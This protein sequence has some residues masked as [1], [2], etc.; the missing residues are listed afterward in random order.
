MRVLSLSLDGTILDKHSL[1]EERMLSLSAAVG[2]VAVLVP[3]NREGKRSLSPHLTVYGVNGS[4][5]E[6]F[7][8]LRR[9]GEKLLK[10]KPYDLIT[11]QDP[12]F[13]GLIAY[14]LARK[15]R[16]PFEVQIHG[17]ERLSGVR[18]LLL[19]FTLK[20]ADRVR[21]VGERLRRFAA[22][23]VGDAKVY[24]LPVY[25]QLP[26]ALEQKKQKDGSMFTFLTVGRLVP[27]KNIALQLRAFAKLREE[28]PHTRLVIVGDGPE[29]DALKAE[30]KRLS[31]SSAVSFEGR[32]RDV[33]PYYAGADAFLLT[34]DS[35][36]WGVAVTE[37]ALHKLPV[38]M[39]DVG[40]AG[41][42]IK[43]GESGIVIPPQN[44]S[45]LLHAMR[46]VAKSRHLRV[47]L[48]EQ[49]YRSAALLPP[50]ETHVARQVDE[51]RRLTAAGE[52]RF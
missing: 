39:T 7:Q 6:Q 35:E 8:K 11:A 10:E 36:G 44:E 26:A 19:R 40:L 51:W 38:I 22:A 4:K 21:V 28:L 46:E 27:I 45:A 34:S 15:T 52:K 9:I 5:K 32:Q 43:N 33:S 41:E 47:R 17:L 2:E 37:A 20:K 23:L 14:A 18:K 25:S 42:I 48:G 24:V 30:A 1:L 13:L 3:S 49:A 29:A 31:I 12:F 50:A 16:V